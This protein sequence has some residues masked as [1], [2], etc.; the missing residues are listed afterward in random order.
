MDVGAG[1][2]FDDLVGVEDE[3][4]FLMHM[5]VWALRSNITPPSSF[6]HYIEM[7]ITDSLRAEIN[8]DSRDLTII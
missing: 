5:V 8:G 4:H 6:I 2:K 1:W 3:T 7:V